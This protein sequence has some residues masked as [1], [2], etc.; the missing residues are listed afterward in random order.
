MAACGIYWHTV[1]IK[2]AN[3]TA[4]A[5]KRD[6][7]LRGSHSQSSHVTQSLAWASRALRMFQFEHILIYVTRI[8]LFLLSQRTSS[9]HQDVGPRCL[10]N[11][12][13]Q[14]SWHY[15]IRTSHFQR[16]LLLWAS[17]LIIASLAQPSAG[18]LSQF[19]GFIWF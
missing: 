15:T 7:E 1:Q 5:V 17:I 10:N 12:S 11:A 6:T 8:H 14:Q 4:T 18:S 9:V 19:C 13:L 2:C 3:Q 16:Q